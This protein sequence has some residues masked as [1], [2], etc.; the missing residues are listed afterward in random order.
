MY[1]V[2]IPVNCYKFHR[3]KDKQP[4]LDELRAFDADRVMLNFE[5]KLDGALAFHNEEE[6]RDAA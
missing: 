2:S 4:I 1:L 5:A 6:Y 3:A